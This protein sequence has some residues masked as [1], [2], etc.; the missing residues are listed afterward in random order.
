MTANIHRIPNPE[1][2]A[3][4]I[5]AIRARKRQEGLAIIVPREDAI[6]GK[7]LGNG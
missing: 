6:Q 1:H 4:C 5:Q 7:G 2:E 3:R